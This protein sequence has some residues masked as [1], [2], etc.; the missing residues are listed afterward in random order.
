MTAIDTPQYYP[1]ILRKDYSI[2]LNLRTSA[3]DPGPILHLFY[4]CGA[5][6]NWR[7]F[8]NREID[9]LIEHQSQEADPVRRKSVCCARSSASW[10]STTHADDSS[11]PG[12]E[13]DRL[14]AVAQCRP[15]TEPEGKN[16]LNRIVTVTSQSCGSVGGMGGLAPGG[17]D[18]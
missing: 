15:M 8:C 10:P 1:R 2:E 5:S 4:G 6:V 12:G 7:G 16:A 14:G 9:R 13:L 17:G 18:G 11:S 3:P